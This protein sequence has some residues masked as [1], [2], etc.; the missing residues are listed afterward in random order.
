MDIRQLAQRIG[1]TLVWPQGVSERPLDI[2]GVDT[3]ARASEKQVSFLTNPRFKEQLFSSKAAAVIVPAVV[4]DLAKPQLVQANAYAAM[5]K[6]AQVFYQRRHTMRGPSPLAFIHDEAKVAKTAT[7]YPYAFVDQGAEIGEYAVLYPHVYI[8]PHAI[9]GA[10]SVLGPAVALMESC[11]IGEDVLVHGGSVIGGDGFGFAPTREGIEKIP[12]VGAAEI[13]PDCEIGA[14]CTVDRGAFE[15][16]VLAKGVKL[17]SHVHIGHGVSVGEHSMLCGMAGVAGSAR[18]GK[19]FIAG[20]QAAVAPGIDIGDHVSLG[21]KA[22]MIASTAEAGEYQGMPSVPI[23]EWRK[24]MVA[25]AKLP[26][27]LKTVRR[28]EQELL[29]LKSA[30]GAAAD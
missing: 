23:K 24:Q 7:I 6:A 28:L 22:G 2:L 17:D 29:A 14:L 27:L 9:V 21:A 19:R 4:A 20:G 1:A 13:G 30:D 26:E 25:L 3:L 15:D 16:T 12:Q 10:R 8:G 18:I 5:A 11:R